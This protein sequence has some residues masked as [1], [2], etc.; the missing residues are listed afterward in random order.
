M[1]PSRQVT[2]A[3]YAERD[4]DLS[5]EAGGADVDLVFVICSLCCLVV[6]PVGSVSR[7]I[8]ELIDEP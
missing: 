3:V 5:R 7:S 2:T 6:A 4:G 8:V 1:F